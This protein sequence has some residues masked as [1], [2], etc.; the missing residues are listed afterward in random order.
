[1]NPE[2]RVLTVVEVNDGEGITTEVKGVLSGL[3]LI[4]LIESL[5]DD[6]PEPV[7]AKLAFAIFNKLK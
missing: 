6:L 5:P 1:M 2:I 7:L 3:G 4:K